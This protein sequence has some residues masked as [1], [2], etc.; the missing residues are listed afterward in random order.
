LL[1]ALIG[2]TLT[3]SL[4]ALGHYLSFGMTFIMMLGLSIYIYEHRRKMP[5]STPWWTKWG[6]FVLMFVAAILINADPFRHV[7]QDLD[8]WES[9]SSSEYRQKCH[10]ETFHC[11]SPLGLYMT[12][13]MTYL[14]FTLL[15]IAALWNANVM[16]KC[17][18]I[19]DQWNDLRGR[20]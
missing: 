20:K 2:G 4:R 13:G 9:P 15:M 16:S 5:A 3:A 11:M 14:G 1:I 10:D 6:P 12:V 17:K 8:I 7:L 18:A 19:K